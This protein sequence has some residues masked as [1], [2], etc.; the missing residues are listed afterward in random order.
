MPRKPLTVDNPFCSEG[1]NLL[2]DTYNWKVPIWVEEILVGVTQ[3]FT[4][5]TTGRKQAIVNW[6]KV[7]RIYMAVDEITTGSIKDYLQCSPTT[8]RRYVDVM[9]LCNIF[10]RRYFKAKIKTGDYVVMNKEQLAY[11]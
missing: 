8:A 6:S 1:E 2:R 5:N 11:L 4:A 7:A 10:I 3:S 9:R